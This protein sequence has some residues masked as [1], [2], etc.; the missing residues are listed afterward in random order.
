VPPNLRLASMGERLADQLRRKIVRGELAAGTHLVEDTLA[1]TYDVSRGPVRD[2]FKILSA[3]GLLDDRRRGFFVRGFS[4]N[5]VDELYSLR[6]S[7]EKLAMELAAKV[8]AADAW[9]APEAQL[10]KMYV[11]ADSGDWRAFAEHDLAFHGTFYAMSGHARLQ[12]L[13]QQYRPLFGAM[14]DV[15]NENDVDLRPSADDHSAL[16]ELTRS[17]QLPAL[18]VRLEEHLAGSRER[19]IAALE[20][21]WAESTPKPN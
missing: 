18:R 16:L 14:L 20:P 4:R 17:G 12:S 6:I 8:A 7:I 15:T 19:M 9:G 11:A 3:E 5:D 1:E 13:W 21:L 2:A 10:A